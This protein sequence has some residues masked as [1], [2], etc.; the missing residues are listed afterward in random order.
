VVIACLERFRQFQLILPYPATTV[1]YER[2]FWMRQRCCDSMCT[3]LDSGARLKQVTVPIVARQGGR[4]MPST[5]ELVAF[6]LTSMI[7]IAIPGPS[8]LCVM[9]S[10][11]ALPTPNR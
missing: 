4:Y 10:S 11:S 8:V 2:I 6:S 3:G 7:L 9:A 5:A 1:L